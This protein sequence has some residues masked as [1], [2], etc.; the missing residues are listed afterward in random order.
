MNQ[1]QILE[2]SEVKLETRRGLQRWLQE[3]LNVLEEILCSTE[4]ELQNSKIDKDD[5]FSINL[6]LLL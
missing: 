2:K 4:I 6:E 3:T 1:H 5:R